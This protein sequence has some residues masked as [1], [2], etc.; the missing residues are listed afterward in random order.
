M[1][2]GKEGIAGAIAA[3]EAWAQRDHAAARG[4]ERDHLDLWLECLGR[5]PGLAVAV[6]P[7]P[8]GNPLDRLQVRVDPEA[9]GTTAWALAAAL[10]AGDPPVV[11]RDEEIEHG[12]LELDPCNL[13]PGEAEIV[14]EAVA[15]TL[16]AIRGRP[17]PTLA[18]L[19]AEEERRLLAWPD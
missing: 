19:R 10:A 9:A 16:E 1:K 4:F 6:V 8:T 13:H 5:L 7:D 17:S 14:A 12:V 18:E 15:R 3:L 11:V 2:V